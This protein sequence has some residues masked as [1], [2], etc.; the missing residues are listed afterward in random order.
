VTTATA[1]YLLTACGSGEPP[2]SEAPEDPEPHET[3]TGNEQPEDSPSEY[4]D[5][6]TKRR[7]PGRREEA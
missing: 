2:A 7:L 5:D 4:P 3:S 6:E 1:A